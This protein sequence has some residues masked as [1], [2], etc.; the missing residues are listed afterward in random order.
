MQQHS[1]SPQSMQ[2]VLPPVAS[3]GLTMLSMV[4]EAA[5]PGPF[6]LTSEECEP[7]AMIRYW[8]CLGGSSS[9]FLRKRPVG[10]RG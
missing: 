8:F 3:A 1:K 2:R 10:S 6:R 7:Q 5:L 9:S 4:E